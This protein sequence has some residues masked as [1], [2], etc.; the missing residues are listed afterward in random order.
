[1]EITWHGRSCFT[2]KGKS[3]TVITDP[4]DETGFSKAKL[5]GNIVVSNLKTEDVKLIPVEGDAKI[6]DFPGE[7]ERLGVAMRGIQAWNMSKKKEEEVKSTGK[8][9]ES[10]KVT[11]FVIEIDGIKICHLGNIGHT[12]TSELLEAVGSV[13]ILLIPVGGKYTI[14]AKKAHEIIEE[15]EPRVVIPMHYKVDGEKL[16]I[17]G[18]EGFLKEIG[19]RVE[20]VEKF[21]V[22]SRAKLPQDREEYVVLEVAG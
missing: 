6:F 4:Y 20:P 3:A 10:K 1:M 21:S 17:A 16:D 12:L 13:D 15:I 14:D 18:V 7:Y 8:G 9:E 22:E 2:I 5:K 11:V 19:A